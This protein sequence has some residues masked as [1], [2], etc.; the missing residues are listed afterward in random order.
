MVVT[1]ANSNTPSKRA[2]L[3]MAPKAHLFGLQDDEYTSYHPPEINAA[4]ASDEVTPR[5]VTAEEF[6]ILNKSRRL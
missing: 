6:E 1:A 4:I 5:I 3:E 2:K